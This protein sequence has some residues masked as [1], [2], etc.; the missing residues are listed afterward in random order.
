MSKASDLLI[1]EERLQSGQILTTSSK[2]P[3]I[4]VVIDGFKREEFIIEAFKS[5]INQTLC[6]DEFELIV[7]RA[8]NN[9]ELDRELAQNK[10]KIFDVKDMTLGEAIAFAVENST[11]EVICF[12]DDDDMFMPNKLSAVESIFKSKPDLC[13][14]HNNQLFCDENSNPISG[15]QINKKKS[16]DISFTNKDLKH[17]LKQLR[18]NKVNPGSLYFNLSSICVR[19]KVFT[20][21][22]SLMKKVTS[23][24]DDL[25]F[26]L[27]LSSSEKVLIMNVSDPL[28][29]YRIHNSM[30]NVVQ[31]VPNLVMRDFRI[32]QISNY[33]NSSK[34]ISEIAQEPAAHILAVSILTYDT[35]SLYNVKKESKKLVIETVKLLAKG[36]LKKIEHSFKKRA[37]TYVGFFSF[38]IFYAMSKRFRFFWK[39]SNVFPKV[40]SFRR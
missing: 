25:V 5:V 31:S 21:K 29:V 18:A 28:T 36:Y 16:I 4:S 3:F 35:A 6:K 10:A 27:T 2:K 1:E 38:A 11:G 39:F 17:S 23:H 14:Y 40:E 32:I 8:F 33:V 20:E 22:L 12:L 15:L 7:L 24:I 13:Y 34:V 9:I 26:F 30:T 19:R 37:A